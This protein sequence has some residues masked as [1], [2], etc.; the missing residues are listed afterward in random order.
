MQTSDRGVL[1]MRK[2]NWQAVSSFD[3]PDNDVDGDGIT[4]DVDNCADVANADQ[5]DIDGDGIG[6]ACDTDADGDGLPNTSD[7]F[8]LV[9]IEGYT[10]TDGDGRPDDCNA[11]CVNAGMTADTDDDNDGVLDTKTLTL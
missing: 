9:S 4:N 6:D 1:K 7:A 3:V 5:P 11:A 2:I 10:D 8:P